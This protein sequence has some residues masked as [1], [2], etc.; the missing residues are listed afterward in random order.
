MVF[1]K[2]LKNIIQLNMDEN[3]K[4]DNAKWKQLRSS[5]KYVY[6]PLMNRTKI[7]NERAR[8]ILFSDS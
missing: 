5:D 4:Y 8:Q 3:D 1:L 7:E 2:Y 6:K